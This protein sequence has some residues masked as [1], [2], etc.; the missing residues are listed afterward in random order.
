M[1]RP[2]SKKIAALLLAVCTGCLS[3][4]PALADDT[5]VYLGNNAGQT[6]VRPNVLFI[7]DTSGSMGTNV[8]T[9]VGVYDPTQT[10][11]GSCDASRYY[12]SSTGSP[13]S[14]AYTSHYIDVG[15]FKCDDAST[16]LTS[17]GNGY[18]VG[19]LGRYNYGR[20]W[21][22]WDSLSRRNHT[23]PVECEADYGVHGDGVDA[24]KLYPADSRNGGPWRTD[25]TNAIDWSSTGGN[26]TFYSANYLNWRENYATTYTQT[27]L[28]IVK[29]TLKSL[30][31]GSSGINAGL[32]RF[33]SNAEGGYF[34]EAIKPLDATHRAD[35]KT[36][37]DAL[38]AGGGTPLAE[39]MYEAGLL[40]RDKPVDYGDSSSP[41]TNTTDVL[42]PSDTSK[43]KTPIEYQCQKNFAVLL[44]DGEPTSDSSADSKIAAMPG[45]ANVTGASSCSGDCLDEMAQYL[46]DRDL[47]SSLND[48]QNVITYTIGF[49]SNQQ[50]LSDTASKGGGKYFLADSADTLAN[51]F[52]SII[53][54]VLAV[55]T[56]FVAPAVT[57]NAF[58]RLTHRDE[59]YF[60]LFKPSSLPR[61]HGNVKRYGIAGD[62]PIVVDANGDSAVDVN[63]GFFAS[64]TQS[65]WSDVAD[66]AEVKAGGAAAEL[67]TSRNLYTYTGGS[68][69][70]NV[71]LTASA[72]ALSENN[73]A[74]S[75]TMLGINAE[76]DAYRTNLLEW[77]RGIDVDDEDE[78]GS[79][80]DA[81][82]FM[83][84]PLHTKPALVTYG[85]TDANPDITLFASTNEGF[86]HAIDTSDGHEQFAF[87]PQALLPN[88]NTLYQN[89]GGD[90]HPYGLDGPITIW[91]RDANGDGLV[92]NADGTVQSG[93]HVYLYIGM[94]RGGNH[95]YALDVTNRSAPKLMWRI[96][97]G[98]GDFAS[99]AQTW[100]R[101]VF[102]KVKINGVEKQVLIFGGGYDTTQDTTGT[103]R[104][105]DSIGNAI[106]MIDANTGARLWWAGPAGSGANLEL[107]GMTNAF[108]ADPRVIDIDLDGHADRLYMADVGGRL[109][110]I[111]FNDANTGAGNLATGYMMADFND[112]ATA[113][114]N[115]HFYYPPDVALIQNGTQKFLSV[116]VGSGYRAHPLDTDVHDRF[117]MIR[118]NDV[119]GPPRDAN[120]NISYP[121]T[122]SE[123]NLYDATANLIG[124]GTATEQATAVTQL[125]G[126]SG[127]YISLDKP[128][129]TWEGEK[130]LSESLTVQNQILFTTFTP[131]V[132]NAV[133]NSCAPSQ[134]TARVYHVNLL[135]ATPVKN[136]DQVG[137]ADALTRSDR[138]VALARGGIPPEPVLL[139]PSQGGAI[140][141]VGPEKLPDFELNLKTERTKWEQIR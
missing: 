104:T 123:S 46:H 80:T 116:A 56:T 51:A 59:L 110:R 20:R 90:E 131:V 124:Q 66:G 111:D 12:W 13:P 127:W 26:Y 9:T 140:V 8:T 129:G 122:L 93:E 106:Y 67:T 139:F 81:R 36:S 2:N 137:S 29:D 73:S 71:T 58:N 55:N 115:R 17:G 141:M 34:L 23:D 114:G 120:G 117:Y 109:W 31:D 78:D 86:L 121:S 53:T 38:T 60:A 44:T 74:I 57:A 100:S 99:L 16:A 65:F 40:F 47:N 37:V 49:Q 134:G 107:S 45:F 113:A 15:S 85:G 25:T 91:H 132:N 79:T 27:R 98:S 7:M 84:D 118:D 19:R 126:S 128:D 28:Q 83:G 50:L 77:A 1:K 87:M 69:P 103:A 112:G 14:C 125:N 94:R 54:E 6:Q 88:L 92:L 43:Y 105:A 82:H 42:D 18:Y 52:T 4:W 39:T 96:D 22:R 76:T 101:P 61:W 3:A 11:T 133:Q 95:Y 119:Y 138:P 130:V 63:T 35:M 102:T 48:T 70:N 62:P 10:Y 33:D 41:G 75:K 30:L 72:N 68:V 21:D 5:E 89:A 108:P 135:D 32:M 136:Y 97:G 24:T 64:G